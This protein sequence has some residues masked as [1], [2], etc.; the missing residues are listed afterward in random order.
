MDARQG[1]AMYEVD[2]K[3]VDLIR[4]VPL[5]P[6]RNDEHLERAIDLVDT[7]LDRAALSTWEQ[8]YLDVLSDLIA[9]YEREHVELP[10]VSGID[11][12]RHLMEEHD[13]RQADLV[14]LFGTKSIVSEVLS[15]KR[16]FALKHVTNLSRHFGVP[17]DVFLDG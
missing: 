7:L 15:G 9:R 17:A 3:Y 4:I 8:G 5:I 11:L 13:L 12:V 6:I 14:P 1:D 2:N 10:R 16:H